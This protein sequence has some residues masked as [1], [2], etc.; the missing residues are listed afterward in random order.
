MK[1][2]GCC[3]CLV[4]WLVY[5]AGSPEVMQN[6]RQLP[7]NTNKGSLLAERSSARGKRQTPTSQITVGPEGTEDMVSALDEQRSQIGVS[8]LRDV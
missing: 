8:F 1:L 5:L 6:Y 7:R 3:S 4:Q 2:L